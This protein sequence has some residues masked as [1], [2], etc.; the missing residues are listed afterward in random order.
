MAWLG[1]F[2]TNV[3]Y[4]KDV[5][6]RFT[7]LNH[8][9]KIINDHYEKVR[10]LA[11]FGDNFERVERWTVDKGIHFDDMMDVNLNQLDRAQ[12]SFDIQPEQNASY[13]EE[14]KKGFKLAENENLD[15]SD[16]LQRITK[17]QSISGTENT[18]SNEIGN[19][20]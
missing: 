7:L 6:S 20:L 13:S 19:T 16:F 3:K 1:Y 5:Y 14:S 17:P 8:R 10:P 18:K 2:P 15:Q 4:N 11:P 9:A 12:T